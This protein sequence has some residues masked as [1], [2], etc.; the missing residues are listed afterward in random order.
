[1]THLVNDPKVFAAEA[2]AGFAAAHPDHVMPVRGGVVRST[3]S[4]TARWRSCSV[5]DPGTILRSLAG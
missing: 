2:V 3:A 1:M 4:P 5:V